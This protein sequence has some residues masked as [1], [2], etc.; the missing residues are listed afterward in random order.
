MESK[1]LVGIADKCVRGFPDWASVTPSSITVSVVSGGLTNQIYLCRRPAA[2]GPADAASGTPTEVLVR[3][4]GEGT[5]ELVD[6]EAELEFLELVSA[7]GIGP[8]CLGCFEGGRVEQFV[9]DAR[10]WHVRDLR[11]PARAALLGAAMAKL[12]AIELPSKHSRLAADTSL[13]KSLAA[14]A[15]PATA[16]KAANALVARGGRRGLLAAAV[17]VPA[18]AQECVWLMGFLADLESPVVF[19]HN[20]L[21]EGNVLELKD[22]S[23]T[24]LDY[25]FGGNNFR[26][27]DFGNLFCEMVMD[28]QGTA[29]PGFVCQPD[30]YP[31]REAQ[32]GFFRAYAPAADDAALEKLMAEADAFAMASHLYWAL[33]AVAQGLNSQ[34]VWGYLEYAQ[35]RSVQYHACKER[36]LRAA[37]RGY[38]VGETF[39]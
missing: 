24:V 27:F 12:H 18:L 29:F 31:D 39:L 38:E 3:V 15:W 8:R 9:P 21:Q 7:E 20:D 2:G 16:Q 23:V 10:T 17:D 35:Q 26:G 25:E 32:L 22:G 34:I 13:A 28:N 1:A 19:C 36:A 37:G 30:C 11:D 33:W 14:G 4:F 5:E 6:R